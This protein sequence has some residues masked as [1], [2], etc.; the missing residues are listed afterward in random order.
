M[1]IVLSVDDDK[2]V[3][4]LVSE[5]LSADYQLESIDN[6]IEAIELAQHSEVDVAIL[7][8]SLPQMNGFELQRVLKKINPNIQTLFLSSEMNKSNLLTALRN[9]ACDFLQKPVHIDELRNSVAKAIDQVRK[10]K[11]IKSAI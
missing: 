2:M 11:Q 6:P 10:L 7:D 5:A 4:E 9:G 1:G 8:I 3:L